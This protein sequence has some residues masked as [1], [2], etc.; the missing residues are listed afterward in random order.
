MK[1]KP[2]QGGE[3]RWGAMLRTGQCAQAGSRPGGRVNEVGSKILWT[4]RR[5]AVGG[6]CNAGGGVIPKP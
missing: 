6:R 1:G 3:V 4:V 2:S 5:G